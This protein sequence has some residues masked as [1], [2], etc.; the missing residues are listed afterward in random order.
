[1]LIWV[2]YISINQGFSFYEQNLSCV[3]ILLRSFL[4]IIP[5][6]PFAQEGGHYQR[7]GNDEFFDSLNNLFMVKL[8]KEV[9]KTATFFALIILLLILD[10]PP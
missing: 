10:Q 6:K 4:R 2:L 3:Y 1:M 5:G 8:R 9:Q 7:R